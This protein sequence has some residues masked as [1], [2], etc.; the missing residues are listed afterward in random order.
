MRSIRSVMLGHNFQSL[1]AVVMLAA[2]VTAPDPAAAELSLV[3]VEQAGCAWCA[4]WNA[5]IAP[6][7]PHTAEGRTAPLRRIDL[8]APIPVDLS[9]ASQPRFT[10]TFILIEDGVEVGR[11]EGYAG[12]EFFWVMLATLSRRAAKVTDQANE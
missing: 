9:L 10:P 6:I 8:H 12:D 3:M 11:I 1:V 5:E 4:R 7:Y 2:S